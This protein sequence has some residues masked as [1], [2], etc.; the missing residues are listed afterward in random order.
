M[1]NQTYV[2]YTRV[3]DFDQCLS[4]LQVFGLDDIVLFHRDIAVSLLHEST[5]CL[6]G[7]RFV[8]VEG[9]LVERAGVIAGVQKAGTRM[10]CCASRW[11]WRRALRMK[12]VYIPIRPPCQR[13]PSLSAVSSAPLLLSQAGD[14]QVQVRTAFRKI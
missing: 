2:A 3:H 11:D 10:T 1:T 7:D 5:P 14:A 6:L 12:L 8:G 4:R 9:H 13:W